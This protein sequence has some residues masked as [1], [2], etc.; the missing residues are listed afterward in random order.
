MEVVRAM[1]AKPRADVTDAELAVLKVLWERG[2]ATIREIADRL[3]PGGAAAQYATVQK[4]LERLETKGCVRRRPAGRA[5]VYAARVDREEL[6]ARRLR[7]TADKL[8]EGSLTPVLT[9]LVSA[10]RLSPE[11]LAT[12]RALVERSDGEPGEG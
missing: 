11:E 3:Y 10:S 4:L 12:L 5:H 1:Q 8:C 2:R 7:D 9:Q 6:I